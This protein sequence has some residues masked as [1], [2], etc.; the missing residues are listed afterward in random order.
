MTASCFPQET[1]LFHVR[2]FQQSLACTRSS[3][4]LSQEQFRKMASTARCLQ[5]WL[6]PLYHP[7]RILACKQCCRLASELESSSQR[8][9]DSWG[10]TLLQAH[11]ALVVEM[12]GEPGRATCGSSTATCREAFS[13]SSLQILTATG[14]PESLPSDLLAVVLGKLV[15]PCSKYRPTPLSS[16]Q[17]ALLIQVAF[18]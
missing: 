12:A 3:Q 8:A 11:K 13:M 18:T 14:S 10:V 4:K 5:R 15:G 16:G 17:L 1:S 6:W 7:L 9:L 2:G